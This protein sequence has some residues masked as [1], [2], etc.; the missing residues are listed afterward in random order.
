MQLSLAAL[1][2]IARDKVPKQSPS[3]IKTGVADS[4][5]GLLRFACN[6]KVSPS[7][8]LSLLCGIPVSVLVAMMASGLLRLSPLEQDVVEHC[9][10]SS[11]K[12]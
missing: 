4:K 7:S 12:L 2:V 9:A 6:D 3:R 1:H 10:T 8:A 11:F 5:K